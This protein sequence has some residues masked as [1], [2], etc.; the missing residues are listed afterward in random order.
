MPAAGFDIIDPIIKRIVAAGSRLPLS[1]PAATC[2][3]KI[4]TVFKRVT[5]ESEWETFNRRFDLVFGDEL[6][7]ENGRLQYFRRGEHGMDL[8][9]KYLEA[10]KP[11][12]ALLW[13]LASIKLTR[14]LNEME[15]YM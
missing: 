10:I 8:V 13:E 4:Y 3:D 9:C 7:D 12:D 6:R 5:G 14:L 2:E 15:Y 11:S 1:L